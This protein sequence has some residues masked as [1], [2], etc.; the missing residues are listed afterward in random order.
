[1][2]SND[3]PAGGPRPPQPQP[4]PPQPPP[5]G[6]PPYPAPY[7]YPPPYWMAP[8]LAPPPRSTGGMGT[9]S[10]ILGIVGFAMAIIP[11]VYWFFYKVS[12]IGA[13][14]Y[15]GVSGVNTLMGLD[16]VVATLAIVFGAVSLARAGSPAAQ[17]S[18]LAR[19]GLALGVISLVLAVI[20]LP[21]VISAGNTASC[22]AYPGSC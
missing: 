12:V 19:V 18:G 8:G 21:L 10:G 9:A 4:R 16:F 3:D 20:F 5:P 14:T 1:M 17:G 15:S 11:T 22:T 2:T 13:Q 7:P 6:H